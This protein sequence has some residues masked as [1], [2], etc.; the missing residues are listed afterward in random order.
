MEPSHC[1][2]PED[3][4]L[5]SWPP[6]PPSSQQS[7]T[8]LV[9]NSTWKTQKPTFSSR[10]FLKASTSQTR[11]LSQPSS[12]WK[13]RKKREEGTRRRAATGRVPLTNHGP[14]LSQAFLM[15]SPSSSMAPVLCHSVAHSME[16]RPLQPQSSRVGYRRFPRNVVAHAP[17]IAEALACLKSA[18]WHNIPL[19]NL[20]KRITQAQGNFGNPVELTI[21]MTQS[22]RLLYVETMNLDDDKGPVFM[23]MGE[24]LPT[25]WIS[26]GHLQPTSKD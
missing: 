11:D 1:R 24:P 21:R 6:P 26:I 20:V 17:L 16:F 8:A 10:T 23:L 12:L 22:W 7:P 14:S 15:T 13:Q 3:I 18:A 9:L 25:T 19:Q 2:L 5:T 4:R